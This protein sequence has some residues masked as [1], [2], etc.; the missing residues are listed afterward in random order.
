MPKKL[1]YEQAIW[2]RTSSRVYMRLWRHLSW[3]DIRPLSCLGFPESLGFHFR[4]TQCDANDQITTQAKRVYD[5]RSAV[6]LVWTSI[7]WQKQAIKGRALFKHSI[8]IVSIGPLCDS[9]IAFAW[10]RRCT[11]NCGKAVAW[12]LLEHG[13]EIN[14]KYCW[15]R[16]PCIWRPG[17][18][19][20]QYW[21]CY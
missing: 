18:V 5:S 15:S 10:W 20:K 7:H 19:T 2:L 16:H 1:D 3:H 17:K 13:A 21:C 9:R 4:E 8:C 12:L 6:Y 11:E 14:P